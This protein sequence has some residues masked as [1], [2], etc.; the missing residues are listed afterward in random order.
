MEVTFEQLVEELRKLSRPTSRVF[1]YEQMQSPGE[2]HD[3][4]ILAQTESRDQ[5]VY[6]HFRKIEG[7][8]K[9]PEN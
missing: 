4:A 1:L 5:T 6:M 3:P 7:Y 2:A 8:E 9:K